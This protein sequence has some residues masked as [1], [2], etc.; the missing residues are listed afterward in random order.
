M[1]VDYKVVSKP[2]PTLGA[3]LGFKDDLLKHGKCK[4]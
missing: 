4:F 1:A 3:A 2:V